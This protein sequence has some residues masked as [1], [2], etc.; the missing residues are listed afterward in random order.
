MGMGACA[1]QY[2]EEAAPDERDARKSSS[3]SAAEHVPA[4]TC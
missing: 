1:F 4:G 3:S 2:A